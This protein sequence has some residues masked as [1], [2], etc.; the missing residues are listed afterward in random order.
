[1]IKPSSGSPQ[2]RFGGGAQ[3]EKPALSGYEE[4]AEGARTRERS[5]KQGVLREL[6]GEKGPK[7]QAAVAAGHGAEEKPGAEAGTKGRAV[8]SWGEWRGR[9]GGCRATAPHLS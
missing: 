4:A 9:A 2:E 7:R 1:M 6:S 8:K 5:R 3:A